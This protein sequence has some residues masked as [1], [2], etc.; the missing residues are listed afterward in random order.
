M[1]L[2]ATLALQAATTLGG[3]EVTEASGLVVSATQPGILWTHNDSGDGPYLYAFDERGRPKATV[4]VRNAHAHDW[5]DLATGPFPGKPGAWLYA[6]DIGDNRRVRPEVC[7]YALPEP[8]IGRSSRPRPLLSAEAIALRARYPDGVAHNAECLLCDPRDGRLTIVTKET[9]GVSGVYRFPAPYVDPYRG[10][11]VL[12]KVGEFRVP[13]GVPLVTGGSFRPDGGAVAL[14]TYTHV[15]ELAG[16]AFWTA[17]PRVRPQP[18][19][20]QL[21]AVAYSRDGR[22]LWLTSEGEHAPL[23]R[24]PSGL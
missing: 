1:V 18:S 22:S 9:S 3:S 21:E 4:L 5:E 6:A 10:P 11:N 15:F 13:I 12:E 20:K 23:I 7:V 17:T 24:I 8:R 14:V 2:L 16:P 19:L